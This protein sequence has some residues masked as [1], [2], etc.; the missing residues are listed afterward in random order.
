[1]QEEQ[2]IR[3]IDYLNVIWRR[4]G[5]IMGGTLIVAAAALLVSLS[6]PKV[7]EVSRTLRIGQLPVKNG[8]EVYVIDLRGKLIHPLMVRF[9]ED[10]E[11]VIG[12]LEDQRMLM[13]IIQEFQLD[14]TAGEMAEDM[15]LVDTRAKKGSNLVVRYRVRADDPQ[16]AMRVADRLAEYI[17]KA[18]RPIFD[19]ELQITK[20]YEAEVIAEIRSMETENHSMRRVLTRI[21]KLPNIDLTAVVLL[22]ANIGE[23]ERK[24]SDLES[25]HLKKTRLSRL[26]IQNTAVIAADAP[27][28]HP[29]KPNVKLNVGLG[30]TFGLTGFTFLAF[31]LEY[32]EKA[33]GK[34]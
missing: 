10:R 4:K 16:L 3:L 13:A 27:P 15:I 34:G 6:M 7:Y 24:I 25:R 20:D 19:R 21:M 5:L 8:K 33:K 30:I 2:E 17:I 9:I 18:H 14:M 29:I 12:R 22:Q 11:T 23:R 28:N 26:G 32:I 31:F 1:M